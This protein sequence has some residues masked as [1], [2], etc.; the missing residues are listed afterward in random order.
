MTLAHNLF[1]TLVVLLSSV[2]V[3]TA[4]APALPEVPVMPRIP[5]FSKHIEVLRARSL[6]NVDAGAVIEATCLDPTQEIILHDETAAQLSICGSLAG[7][8]QQCEGSP[9]ETLGEHGTARFALS[10]VEEGATINLSKNQW[11]QCVHAARAVC[12]K[13]SLSAVCAGGASS[14]NVAFTLTNPLEGVGEL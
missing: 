8:I 6:S 1:Q 14:G 2:A 9:T 5:S 7:S 12:P 11:I 13:G 4:V 3:A 10:A